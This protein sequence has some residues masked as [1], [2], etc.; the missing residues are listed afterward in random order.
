MQLRYRTPGGLRIPLKE[1]LI[2]WLAHHMRRY[3]Q[4]HTKAVLKQYCETS[5]KG[6]GLSLAVHRAKVQ[7]IEKYKDKLVKLKDDERSDA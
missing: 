6:V 7:V 2:V 4:S 5:G 3:S 1:W